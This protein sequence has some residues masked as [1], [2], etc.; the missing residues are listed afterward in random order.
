[1]ALVKTTS[2]SPWSTQVS[3]VT[4]S[5]SSSTV[6]VLR[7]HDWMAVASERRKTLHDIRVWTSIDA[8]VI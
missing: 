4:T 1:M 8:V 2:P 7:S 5:T 3:D 6:I